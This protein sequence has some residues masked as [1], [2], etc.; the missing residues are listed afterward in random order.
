MV[1]RGDIVIGHTAFRQHGT[2]AN[3]FGV[4]IG[5]PTLSDHIFPKSRAIID[6]EN[7]FYCARGSPDGPTD[8][9]SQWSSGS[10]AFIRTFGSAPE[11]SLG[12]STGT[13][14]GAG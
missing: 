13:R 4:T 1:L 9:G 3:L 2:D 10:T 14:K 6:P 12:V 5:G 11:R 8:D 7:S